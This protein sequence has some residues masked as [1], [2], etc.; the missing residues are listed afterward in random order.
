MI[1]EKLEGKGFS[2]TAI[3]KRAGIDQSSISR[4]K[5]SERTPDLKYLAKLVTLAETNGI[6]VPNSLFRALVMDTLLA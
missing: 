1:L 5:S 4:Y 2:Q 3:S 6:K